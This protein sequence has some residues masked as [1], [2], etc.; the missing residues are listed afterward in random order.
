MWTLSLSSTHTLNRGPLPA[1]EEYWSWTLLDLCIFHEEKNNVV[2]ALPLT[3][4]FGSIR[5]LGGA[6]NL[7]AQGG[8]VVAL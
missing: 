7:T 4:Y 6:E 2:I 8:Y 1:L 3:I 5:A